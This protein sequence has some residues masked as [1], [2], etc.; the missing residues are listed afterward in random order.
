MIKSDYTSCPI[1]P[2]V[3]I[4]FWN[5]ELSRH[6]KMAIMS[7]RSAFKA[8]VGGGDDDVVVA[9]LVG[10]VGCLRSLLISVA[11]QVPEFFFEENRLVD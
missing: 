9:L 10:V 11:K 2:R 5:L 8:L 6:S 7:S 3:N 1:D 4:L